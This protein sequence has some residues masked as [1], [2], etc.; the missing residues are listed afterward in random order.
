MRSEKSALVRSCPCAPPVW[1]RQTAAPDQRPGPS[2]AR[3]RRPDAATVAAVIVVA[4]DLLDS[5]LGD[6][7]SGA[8]PGLAA[9]ARQFHSPK[10]NQERSRT[11][12]RVTTLTEWHRRSARHVHRTEEVADPPRTTT[13]V[14]ALRG[15]PRPTTSVFEIK[16]LV[17]QEAGRGTPAGRHSAP[18]TAAFSQVRGRFVDGGRWQV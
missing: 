14:N 16:K 5:W 18:Q 2:P 3:K 7:G 17:K 8:P 10:A 4:L 9:H 6:P 1:A 12:A 15:P 13:Q 11:P